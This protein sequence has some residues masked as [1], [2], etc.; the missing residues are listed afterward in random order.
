VT[1]Y[2]GTNDP[3]G[4]VNE[5]YRNNGNFTFTVGDDG[6]PCAVAAGGTGGGRR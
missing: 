3:A 5:V 4:E 1:N 2:L 6:A